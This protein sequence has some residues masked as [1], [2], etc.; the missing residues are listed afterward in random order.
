MGDFRIPD[1][2]QSILD[3]DR[4]LSLV[5]AN[6]VAQ[7]EAIPSDNKL[8]FFPDF[9][10]H[11]I[12]H[13]QLVLET[14]TSL[15]P[16][17]L[18]QILTA[19]DAFVLIVASL[20]H[21]LGMHIYDLGFRNLISQTDLALVSARL[22]PEE[23]LL[24]KDRPWDVVWKTFVAEARRWDDKTNY[25]VFGVPTPAASQSVW[26][27]YSSANMSSD[28]LPRFDKTFGIR[29]IGEFVRRNHA[30]I[31]HEIPMT[32]FPGLDAGSTLF[33]Q[34]GEVAD[35]AGFVARSH[36]YSIRSCADFATTQLGRRTGPKD[37]HFAYI[38]ALLRLSDYL[39]LDFARA[40][41]ALFNVR[42]PTNPVSVREWQKHSVLDR[43]S[44]AGSD[45][46]V[47]HFP[48]VSDPDH[49]VFVALD[50]LLRDVQREFDESTPSSISLLEA[51]RFP[52]LETF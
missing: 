32:G 8:Y 33:N 4:E 34:V 36:H 43:P 26:N 3:R 21:D 28:E 47:I 42:R 27:A 23:P 1:R 48:I 29:L 39:Q 10:D 15:I 6:F 2:L 9:T 45:S 41:T 20:V 40:N 16:D 46:S 31:A 49:S 25:S 7:L 18:D 50:S 12:E 22:A 44:F 24:P 38:M 30:R 19:G 37:V 5:V 51:G 35:L 52:G 17:D 14:A 11:G 13:I